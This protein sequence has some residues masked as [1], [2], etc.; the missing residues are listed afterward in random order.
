[1]GKCKGRGRIGGDTEWGGEGEGGGGDRPIKDDL[2]DPGDRERKD[3]TLNGLGD[4]DGGPRDDPLPSDPSP[5]SWD[6]NSCEF[7]FRS[8]FPRIF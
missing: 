7:D 1:M 8:N 6:D 4:R 3:V 5:P 2:R